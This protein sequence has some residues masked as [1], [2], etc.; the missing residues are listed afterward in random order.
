[1]KTLLGVFLAVGLV[2]ASSS[3]DRPAAP[4]AESAAAFLT[5]LMVLLPR[6]GEEFSLEVGQSLDVRLKGNPTTGYGWA[7]MSM[8]GDAVRCP[9]EPEYQP[10]PA[11][12][13]MVG[14]GG[15]FAIRLVGAKPGS[16]KVVLG[17]RRPWEKDTLPAERLT[18][19]FR[20]GEDKT[21]E[22]LKALKANPDAFILSLR[23]RGGKDKHYRGLV[24]YGRNLLVCQFPPNT[25]GVVVSKEEVLRIL[26]YLAAD[27]YLARAQNNPSVGPLGWD[28]TGYSV[29]VEGQGATWL[30]EYLGWNPTMLR[31]LDGLRS[32]LTGEAAKAMNEVL[33]RLNED[34]RK[35]AEEAVPP[36]APQARR[37]GALHPPRGRGN[38]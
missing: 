24:L 11:P 29:S 36:P 22:R 5:P 28:W 16:A 30:T 27:G 20:V 1:M 23:Y 3:P 7:V 34:R 26:D 2:A 25:R 33:D 9:G 14:V 37:M 17:Y 31:R 13:G 32:V 19:T 15:W 12:A 35:W 4:A 18:L 8:E 10:D 21:A 6:D 38:A